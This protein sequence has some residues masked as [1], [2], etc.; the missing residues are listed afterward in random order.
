MSGKQMT[1]RLYHEHK[2]K[3]STYIKKAAE[4]TILH[5]ENQ[6][7]KTTAAMTLGSAFHVITLESELF[8]SQFVY[9][10][11]N[12]RTKIGKERVAELDALGVTILSKEENEK[13]HGMYASLNQH[14]LAREMFKGGVSEMSH[15]AE[16]EGVEAKCRTDYEKNGKIIDLK[17]CIDASP[18]G[19][20]SAVAKYGYH[21]QV[22][23]YVDVYNAANDTKLTHEDFFFVCVENTFPY[24][25]AVYTLDKDSYETGQKLYKKVLEEYKVYKAQT[26]E[27]EANLEAGYYAGIISLSLPL[28]VHGKADAR[29]TKVEDGGAA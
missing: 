22:A 11:I 8:G 17:S 23:Y 12:K 19:F 1:N 21:I 26:S 28:W 25:V 9:E 29:V 14:P 6:V 24:A 20:S 3:G 16:I 4:K 7:F 18:D 27:L 13:V 10:D 15:F 5:A 2:A